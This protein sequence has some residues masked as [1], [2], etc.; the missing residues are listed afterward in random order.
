MNDAIE[1]PE[2]VDLGI[3]SL[4]NPIEQMSDIASTKE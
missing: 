1:N 3:Q 2:K 4:D